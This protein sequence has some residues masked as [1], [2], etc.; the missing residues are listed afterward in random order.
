[1]R[2]TAAMS[3]SSKSGPAMTDVTPAPPSQPKTKRRSIKTKFLL[4]LLALSLLPLILIVAMGYPG[5]VYV[6]ERMGRGDLLRFANDVSTIVGVKLDKIAAAT[7]TAA[8]ATQALLR[9]PSAFG[10]ARSECTAEKPDSPDAACSYT[11]APGVSMAAAKPVLDLSGNLAK[12]LAL[13]KESDPSLEAIYY[14]TQSG[15]YL[16]YPW[17]YETLNSLEFTLE[18]AFAQDLN[19]GGEIPEQMRRAFSQSGVDLSRHTVVS[20]T[21]PGNEWLIRD[22]DHNRIFSVRRGK[23]G[24]GVSWEYDPRDAPWYLDAVGRDGVVWTKYV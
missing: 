16:E 15:V 1:M 7:R 11:L 4:A 17:R 5:I 13:V 3:M 18:R 23:T 20:T 10:E 2:R 12:V 14:G 21:D 22:D 6:Q 24:L 19:G 8:F 9:N